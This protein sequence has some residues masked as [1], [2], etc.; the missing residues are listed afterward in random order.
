[1]AAYFGNSDI[2]EELIFRGAQ[3]DGGKD[4]EE[5]T[6]LAMA[7]LNGAVKVMNML[8]NA[9]ADVNAISD[10]GPP[11]AHAVD[12]GSCEA[13]RL[14]IGKGAHISPAPDDRFEAPLSCAARLP[15]SAAFDLLMDAGKDV[16]THLDFDTAFVA[17]ADAGNIGI[18]EK[19]LSYDHGADI[20]QEALERATEEYE[21]EVVR[22]LLANYQDLNCDEL[23]EALATGYDNEDELLDVVWK[24]SEGSI[25]VQTLNK[26]LYHATDNE[27]ESTVK[28][29]LEEC[30]ADPNATG[31][32]YV[33][34]ICCRFLLTSLVLG[35]L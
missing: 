7:A 14:L 33:L 27:K 5:A 6:P 10:D 4:R 13:V 35:T 17:A 29:L 9:G 18:I 31:E 24:Y 32:E 2:V 19:L 21:W 25:S 26:S 15:D 16:L 23:F 22:L 28:Y 11:L 8:L 30:K 1:M 20:T 34:C 3:V 12:S